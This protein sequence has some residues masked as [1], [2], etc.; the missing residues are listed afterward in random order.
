MA[1]RLPCG[2][3]ACAVCE[4]IF[5]RE[6]LGPLM[7]GPGLLSWDRRPRGPVGWRIGHP[8][9]GRALVPETWKLACAG[10]GGAVGKRL[11]ADD[12]PL[13]SGKTSSTK[14]LAP[15]L[16]NPEPLWKSANAAWAETKPTDPWFEMRGRRGG[17]R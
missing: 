7:A 10:C 17:R 11:V 6:S 16:A 15:G 4:K 8:D 14:V 12:T 9:F 13:R 2:L 5:A 3:A 1:G